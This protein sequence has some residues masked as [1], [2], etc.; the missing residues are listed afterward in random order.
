M[1]KIHSGLESPLTFTFKVKTLGFPF[2][3]S[4]FAMS[5]MS[6]LAG[7][8]ARKACGSKGYR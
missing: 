1:N 8:T 4:Y 5:V 2:A 6:S 3:Y 7:L